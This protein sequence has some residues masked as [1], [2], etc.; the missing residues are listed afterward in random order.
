MV[1]LTKWAMVRWTVAQK[2]GRQ[3]Q[4]SDGWKLQEDL[5]V[6]ASEIFERTDEIKLNQDHVLD[7]EA[8]SAR[9]CKSHLCTS[10]N[11]IP[12]IHDGYTL[13]HSA[14]ICWPETCSAKKKAKYNSS[15]FTAPAVTY[16]VLNCLPAYD[17]FRKCYPDHKE[18]RLKQRSTR[19]QQ[20]WRFWRTLESLFSLN[21]QSIC[22]K[23]GAWFHASLNYKSL[24]QN[25]TFTFT[26]LD[27]TLFLRRFL[28][29][30]NLKKL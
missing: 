20:F 26:F 25:F 5:L 4:E 10:T 14:F 30:S 22:V 28:R 7:W 12:S 2:R 21:I 15:S 19:K 23:F 17:W 27:T 18:N 1:L 29:G 11:P 3:H 9:S 6:S 24:S 13:I 16:I 8:N